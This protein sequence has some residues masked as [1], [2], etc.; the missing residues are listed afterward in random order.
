MLNV[1]FPIA[2]ID[3]KSQGHFAETVTTDAIGVMTHTLII[4]HVKI[5]TVIMAS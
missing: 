3:S 4:E 5:V 1:A 2:A